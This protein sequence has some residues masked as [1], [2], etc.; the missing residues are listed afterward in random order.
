MDLPDAGFHLETHP[1]RQT[2]LASV[3]EGYNE[4][5]PVL[6]NGREKRN[7]MTVSTSRRAQHHPSFAIRQIPV[8]VFN[9]Q[10]RRDAFVA[11]NPDPIPLPIL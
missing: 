9:F 6:F 2:D 3:Q 1:D 8:L 11:C 10:F 5:P 7:G 4:R